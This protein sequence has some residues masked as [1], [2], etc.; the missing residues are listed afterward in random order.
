MG[1]SDEEYQ[2][3]CEILG[4]DP[5]LVEIGMFSVMWSE[6]CSYKNS[7]R[8]LR[9]LP[10][11]GPCVLE[12]PGENAG[13]VDIGDGLAIVFKIESHNHPSAVEPYQGAATGVGGIIRDI[14]TM[15]ARPIAILDSLRF[16]DLSSARTRTL[17]E[18][19]V[20][21]ISGYGNAVGI[22]T[23]GGEVWFHPSYANNPL[24]N[25][26]C[27]G[28]MRHED[29]KRGA[30][31]GTGNSVMVIGA[32][33]GRDGI[34]GATFASA[35]L[36]DEAVERR[37]A[38]QVGDPFREKLLLEACLELV[39][40]GCVLGIQDMGAAGL[41]CSSCEMASRGDSG[42]V[43]DLDK[44]PRRESGM[45]PYE[46]MLSE[47]QERMLLVPVPGKEDEVRE[48]L[49][50]W[51]LEASVVGHVTEDGFITIR[52]GGT[53]VAQVPAKALADM[54][55]VYDREAREPEYI[56][57]L[58]AF[59]LSSITD[60]PDLGDA[61]LRLLCSPSIASKEWVYRQYDHQV[62]AA[63]VAGPGSDAAV[64]RLSGTSKGIA[65]ATDAN[66]RFCYLDPRGGAALAVA[67]AA[68]NVACA[69]A[70]PL[71]ITNCLNFGNPMKPEVFWQFRECVRGM[72]DACLALGTP[73]TG[74][75]VS[76]Y[77]EDGETAIY[78]TPVIGMVGVLEDVSRRVPSGFQRAGDTIVLLGTTRD[79]IGGS[80]YLA[81]IGGVEAGPIPTLSLSAE[82]R[83]IDLLVR[84]GASR[85]IESAHDLS[86]GGL[87]VALA[88]CCILGDVGAHVSIETSLPP[89]RYLFSESA[90]RVLVTVRPEQVRDL[91][92]LA[93][94]MGVE[95]TVIGTTGG[96]RLFVEFT[97]G[98]ASGAASSLD[99][100]VS[101]I[102]RG[103]R[104]A[105]PCAM[106]G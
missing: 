69:G 56:E 42:M 33:T 7:K 70:R 41:T 5:G 83:L 16:G 30:A 75:N 2:R 9:T 97:G 78:P 37:S 106:Q 59:D 43:V 73:V 36:T 19:V 50:K 20:S 29:I 44:V 96:C 58:R 61:L 65:L 68:R 88:E 21:G 17:F 62:G 91:R 98:E 49:S 15:G 72:K 10:T 34:H 25:A 86:E 40:R 63:T 84:A 90:S 99:L 52:E 102:S 104:E 103:Y 38:V 74:G 26:M 82:A 95:A 11:S 48:I 94:D 64:L 60:A 32:R 6:H 39:A 93:A 31:R 47:S 101:D 66:A 14:F 105:I 89:S 77:N 23:V 76:F 27:V 92:S 79:E 81:L 67:E 57:R 4:R 13:I 1:L 8:V 87:G 71:A 55:P 35:D 51:E 3:I 53:I 100:A 80:A 22:P 45:T 28:V 18:G 24:V 46:V 85:L 54:A 12:G